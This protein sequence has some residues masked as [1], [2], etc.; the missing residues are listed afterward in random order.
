MTAT[1]DLAVWKEW[2]PQL[3]AV[4][5]A[6]GDHIPF[7]G[8]VKLDAVGQVLMLSAAGS[9]I[10]AELAVPASVEEGGAV[11]VG[12]AVLQMSARSAEK[13]VKIFTEPKHNT[14][15]LLS[16][17][18]R[19]NTQAVVGEFPK[20]NPGAEIRD[21]VLTS[22]DVE[23]WAIV[24]EPTSNVSALDTI[25]IGVC[26]GVRRLY[27]SAVCSPWAS[28]VMWSMD[29]NA[30]PISAST[31]R[32]INPSK[33][34]RFV[35]REKALDIHR[36]PIMYR[37]SHLAEFMPDGFRKI[38]SVIKNVST[39]ILLKPD[40]IARLRSM[41]M[42]AVCGFGEKTLVPVTFTYESDHLFLSCSGSVTSTHSAVPVEHFA[43]PKKAT[44]CV[45]GDSIVRT[46]GN[47]AGSAELHFMD[48][49]TAGAM[50]IA[51][52]RKVVSVRASI[53]ESHQAPPAEDR[54]ALVRDIQDQGQVAQ[55]PA[56][57]DIEEL[58]ELFAPVPQKS[59]G[60][61]FEL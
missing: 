9:S 35:F 36:G 26:P 21:I 1:V 28:A 32:K 3:L 25:W 34:D 33:G 27:A 18:L 39:K 51:T 5:S 22:D 48:G 56:R 23:D 61:E 37:L 46:L 41:L 30:V 2:V 4:C 15:T 57:L 53:R 45:A 49:D 54:K 17:G 42:A 11:N 47:I 7:S 60:E 10:S 20:L 50:V 44:V 14:V 29:A 43:G 58:D 31:L 38:E 13:P 8:L 19:I 12:S 59:P 6:R 16:N 24:D 55:A 40:S 52:N